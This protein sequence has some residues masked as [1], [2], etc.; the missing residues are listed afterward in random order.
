MKRIN[1][2][3]SQSTMYWYEL[4]VSNFQDFDTP[5]LIKDDL[6]KQKKELNSN[7]KKHFIYFICSRKKIRFDITKKIKKVW[8]KDKVRIPLIIGKE[9]KKTS[10][11]ITFIDRATGKFTLPKID[12]YDKFITIHDLDGNKESYP[13]HNFLEKM[14]LDI[15]F[16]SKVEY[17]GYTMNPDTRPTNGA[18]TGLSDAL[19]KTDNDDV[20]ILLY[21]NTF[22]TICTSNQNGVDVSVEN[23]KAKWLS[24][25]DEGFFIEKSFIFYFDSVNQFRNKENESK[26]LINLLKKFKSRNKIDNVL[27]YYEFIRDT[28]YWELTSTKCLPTRSHRFKVSLNGGKWQIT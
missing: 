6:K 23:A 8:F 1:I 11:D 20:D 4:L 9:K 7:F 5:K 10:I 14:G 16:P 22:N 21:F 27:F 26:E 3:L 24:V 13:I 15:G 2:E 12:L 28:E 17:V 18:H 25:K 19:Y